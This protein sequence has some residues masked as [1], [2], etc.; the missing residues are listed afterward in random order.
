MTEL[1]RFGRWVFDKNKIELVEIKELDGEPKS[2]FD[3]KRHGVLVTLT[4]GK[5]FQVTCI[6]K[7]DANKVLDILTSQVKPTLLDDPINTYVVNQIYY[8]RKAIED[9]DDAVK[10]LMRSFSK[11]KKKKKRED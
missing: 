7:Y 4:G 9:L 1:V 10:K 3:K 2:E 8:C 11:L 6:D 5:C